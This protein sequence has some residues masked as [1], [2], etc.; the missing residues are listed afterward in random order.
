MRAH[1]STH[2]STRFCTASLSCRVSISDTLRR[3][4]I[5]IIL[6]HIKDKIYY[7]LIIDCIMCNT[8]THTEL[9]AP[10]P[11]SKENLYACYNSFTFCAGALIRH[12]GISRLSRWIAGAHA[13]LVSPN[14]HNKATRTLH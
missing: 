12:S 1:A 8:Y 10:P 4:F 2:A 5:N 11:P 7:V 13:K 9:C 14:T 3:E 6:V